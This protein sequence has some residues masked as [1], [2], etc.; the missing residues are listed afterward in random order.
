MAPAA[1]HASGFITFLPVYL[2]A[3]PPMGSNIETPSGLMFPPAAMPNP[4]CMMAARSVMIS[5]K[6]FSVTITSYH[7]GCL[8]N[9]IVAASTWL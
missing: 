6:R 2:G 8:T 4:P 1:M 9:H 3:L 5:P 7:S